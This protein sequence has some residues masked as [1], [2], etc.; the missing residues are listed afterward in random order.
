MGKFIDMTGWVMAEHGVPESRLTVIERAEDSISPC[1]A[2]VTMWKCKCSCGNISIV[3]GNALRGTSKRPTL[4]CGCVWREKINKWTEEDIN[5]LK[6]MFSNKVATD[7]IAK[8]LGRKVSAIRSKLHEIGL[9]DEENIKH[10]TDFKAI[11]QDYGWCYERFINR[12]M[13]MHE[14]ANEAGCTLRVMQKWC[15]EKH[16]LNDWTFRH[17]KRLNNLQRQIIMFGLLGDGHIDRRPDQPMYIESHAENQKDYVFWKYSILKDICNKEPVYKAP[18]VRHFECGDYLCQAAYRIN[19]RIIDEL[20]DIRAM[21]KTEII[22]QLNELGICLHLLDDGSRGKSNWSVCVAAFSEEEKHA[23]I[24]IC[25]KRFGLK[26]YI[27][28]DAR[29]IN[30]KADD[31]RRIDRMILNNIP[32]ELDIVK[33]K[34]LENNKIR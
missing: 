31:S 18:V 25:G 21:T 10:R 26:P 28:S 6:K 2:P 27:C 32:N 5:T 7:I 16:G 22:L 11:Y 3:S 17:E 34:I 33:Y 13:D 30:F 9:V 15:S 23:Y 19:T 24:D 20:A 14:M 29:Y 1:G 8:T 4:S 12:G